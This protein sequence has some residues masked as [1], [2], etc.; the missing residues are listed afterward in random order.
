M[1]QKLIPV[2]VMAGLLAFSW[3]WGKCSA[4]F[5]RRRGWSDAA[6][7]RLSLLCLLIASPLLAVPGWFLFA[8][9]PLM[10]MLARWA[11]FRTLCPGR[12]LADLE[13]QMPVFDSKPVALNLGKAEPPRP[14]Q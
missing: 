3:F 14:A 12:R 11:C 5:A 8:G 9:F 7:G 4:L 2:A 6:A 1:E 10:L 13:E